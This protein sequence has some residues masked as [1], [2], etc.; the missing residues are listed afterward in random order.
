[1]GQIKSLVKACD[2]D[3]DGEL[4]IGEIAICKTESTKTNMLA[5]LDVNNDGRIQMD[6]IKNMVKLV[7]PSGNPGR[8]AYLAEVGKFKDMAR[9]CNID[10]DDGSG[11]I[12]KEEGIACLRNFVNTLKK[13][14][15]KFQKKFQ[16]FLFKI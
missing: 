3:K 8:E 9:D 10:N 11:T 7:T 16:N 12:T 15:K 2:T 4:N 6:E 1:V 14:F 13:N 5:A